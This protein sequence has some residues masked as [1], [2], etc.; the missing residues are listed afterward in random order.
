METETPGDGLVVW[1]REVGIAD[2]PRVG[3]KNASLGEMLR[4]LSSAGVRVPDGFAITADAYR[5]FLRAAGLDRRIPEILAGLDPRDVEELARRGAA[6]REA[7]RSAPLPC[8]GCWRS[9]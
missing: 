8:Q 1:F 2:V 9:R 7:I 4:E 3:G 6:L 5:A